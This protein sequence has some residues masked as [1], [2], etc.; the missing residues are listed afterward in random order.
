MAE[1]HGV[2]PSECGVAL[3]RQARGKH[4]L[5]RRREAG[6]TRAALGAQRSA[7]AARH[8]L[9]R[10]RGDAFEVRLLYLDTRLGRLAVDPVHDGVRSAP[11]AAFDSGEEGIEDLLAVLFGELRG[12]LGVPRA[13]RAQ[14]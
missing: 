14:G 12:G 3:A 6:L 7:G 13:I 8:A 4:R 10:H 5:S 2:R 11:V 1:S 9:W